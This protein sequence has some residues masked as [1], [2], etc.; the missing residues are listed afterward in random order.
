MHFPSEIVRSFWIAVLGSFSFFCIGLVDDFIDLPAGQRL[1]V[2]C[3]VS[4]VMWIAGVRIDTLFI[5]AIG[6]TELHW[7]SLPMTVIWITGIVNAIN[8]NDGLDGLAAGTSSIAAATCSVICIANGQMATALIC[9]SL[10][11]SLLGFLAFNFNPAQIFMGDGGSYFVGSLLANISIVGLSDTSSITP[12]VLPLL[13]LA[14]PIADMLFVILARLFQGVS[15]FCADNRH[16]HH[17]LMQAGLTHRATVILIWAIAYWTAS[18]ALV[19]TA[20]PGGLLVSASA[21]VTL[22][23]MIHKA[24]SLWIQSPLLG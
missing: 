14:V 7:L 13:V 18:I 22:L 8:W 12:V 5:P 16:L 1:L 19:L 23:V 2:Q 6:I 21:T 11:G 15:P 4:A 10:L 20:A 17:R 3:I 24:R 9:L